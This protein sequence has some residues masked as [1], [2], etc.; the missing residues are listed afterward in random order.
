M[1]G[2]SSFPRKIYLVFA[3]F[4]LI[5]LFAKYWIQIQG[6]KNYILSFQVNP[7]IWTRPILKFSRVV[8]RWIHATFRSIYIIFRFIVER[9]TKTRRL[10]LGGTLSY[11]L[12]LPCNS[13]EK[14]KGERERESISF[15]RY[16]PTLFSHP[17]LETS[18]PPWLSPPCSSFSC[19]SNNYR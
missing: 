17:P 10:E 18:Q 1:E 19:Q 12:C 4:I 14:R 15:S 7:S 11:L 16:G 2:V 3:N 13:N 9:S 8:Q 6:E 5:Q